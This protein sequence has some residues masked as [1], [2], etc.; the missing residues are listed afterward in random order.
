[1]RG[2]LDKKY[3][4]PRKKNM[5]VDKKHEYAK[6]LYK[7]LFCL[8]T[9]EVDNG[10]VQDEMVHSLQVRLCMRC[11]VGVISNRIGD[12]ELV[13]FWAHQKGLERM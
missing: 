2:F 3:I 1:M 9:Y 6:C 5:H 12:I 8:Q 4:T 7:K 11:Q 13:E 10:G